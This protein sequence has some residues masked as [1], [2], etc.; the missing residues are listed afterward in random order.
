MWLILAVAVGAGV[1]YGIGLWDGDRWW[2]MRL[3]QR[4]LLDAGGRVLDGWKVR[5]AVR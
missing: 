5:D 2:R 1:G 3:R 4:G